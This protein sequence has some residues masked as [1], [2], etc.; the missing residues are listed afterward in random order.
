LTLKQ[1]SVERQNDWSA[2]TRTTLYKILSAALWDQALA[3]G[4]LSGSADDLRDGFIHLS[5]AS[6]IAGTLTKHFAGQRDLLLI[7]FDSVDLAPGLKWEQSRGGED[8]PHY[9]GMLPTGL[10]RQ[11]QRVT[12][13]ADGGVRYDDGNP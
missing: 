1:A 12:F 9:Y 4:Y 3:D 5:S 7:A 6:Q 13:E 8:F 2:M 11:Q 10:A